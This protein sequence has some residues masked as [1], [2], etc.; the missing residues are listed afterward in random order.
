MTLFDIEWS[1]RGGLF[2]AGLVMG[3][4]LVER[5]VRSA[6]PR[7][8]LLH[9]EKRTAPYQAEGNSTKQAEVEEKQQ[10]VAR[11]EVEGGRKTEAMQLAEEN[12][13]Q[14]EIEVQVKRQA[15]A[16]REVEARQVIEQRQV[17]AQSRGQAEAVAKR[18]AEMRH[19]A[20]GMVWLQNEVNSKQIDRPVSKRSSDD[21]LVGKTFRLNVAGVTYSNND[22]SSRK[23]IL[24]RCSVGENLKLLREPN[25]P[26]D[27]NAVA[28][29]R[30]NGEQLGY[31]P[32]E[33]AKQV[34]QLLDNG[35]SHRV[36]IVDFGWDWVTCTIDVSI[37]G[38]AYRETEAQRHRQL[39]VMERDRRE[40]EQKE[41]E[42]ADL[43][44]ASTLR[45]V[46]TEIRTLTIHSPK[47][48][49]ERLREQIWQSLKPVERSGGEVAVKLR[50][51]LDRVDKIRTGI[52][53][54]PED[55]TT[56]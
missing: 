30:H 38:E 27:K 56:S 23:A 17:P 36:E 39:A 51:L 13:R 19:L 34:S 1:F 41:R 26:Y 53:V 2:G 31:L 12:R 33:A 46:Q 16:R 55:H 29:T 43:R 5:I 50:Q 8:K 7:Y 45:D 54:D 48:Q 18:E 47:G 42:A 35:C 10:V 28:V 3:A 32:R 40:R 9:L 14:A 49:I 21:H 25:N 11:Q 44:A 20:E 37:F 22:G 24:N 6:V 4:F 52:A 15:D